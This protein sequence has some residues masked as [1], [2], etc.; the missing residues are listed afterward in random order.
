[1]GHISVATDQSLVGQVQTQFGQFN[2]FPTCIARSF[3]RFESRRGKRGQVD[4]GRH[5]LARDDCSR[6]Q[7]GSG[8]IQLEA[9]DLI[10][11]MPVWRVCVCV[12]AVRLQSQVLNECHMDEWRK[13]ERRRT[14]AD[15]FALSDG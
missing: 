15:T 6:I 7:S 8:L 11:S 5:E 1:M 13:T 12:C 3:P 9:N 4:D 10:E 14:H 2:A